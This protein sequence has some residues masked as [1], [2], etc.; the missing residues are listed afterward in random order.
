MH[1]SDSGRNCHENHQNKNQVIHVPMIETI[2]GLCE[3]KKIIVSSNPKV[4]EM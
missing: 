1:R 3:T 2:L 4:L